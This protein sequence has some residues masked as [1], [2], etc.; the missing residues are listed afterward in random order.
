M[1]AQAEYL[2]QDPPA[3]ASAADVLPAREAS[4][5]PADRSPAA[6]CSR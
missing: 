1:A 4:I 5:V 6:R 2:E 3:Q